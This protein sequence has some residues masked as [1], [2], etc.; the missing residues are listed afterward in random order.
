[1]S[2]KDPW[3]FHSNLSSSLNIGLLSPLEIVN[4]AL[5]SHAPI[6]SKE[7]F[8]RQLIGWRE[9]IRALYMLEGEKMRMMNVLNHQQLLS[10]AFYKGNTQIKVVD[11]TIQKFT[12]YAYLHHIERLMILGNLM[13]LTEVN[14]SEVYRYFMAMSIDAY[15]WVMVPNVYGM[16]QFACGDL[17]TT[18]PYFSSSNY[19]LNMGV[20]S[21]EWKE[22]WDALFYMFLKKH[23]KLIVQNPRLG[24]LIQNLDRKDEKT[25]K[26]YELLKSKFMDI[27]VKK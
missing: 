23:R 21:G 26:Q 2:E 7:G 17:M 15:D 13:L 8:I 4:A 9:F 16:S 27:V 24:V 22:T 3:L 14:P 25:I 12:K 10:R 20:E 6:S 19:L 5:N 11:F 1:M 18:K